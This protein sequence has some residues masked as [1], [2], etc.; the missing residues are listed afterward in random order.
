MSKVAKKKA[1]T[2]PHESGTRPAVAAPDDGPDVTPEVE[3]LIYDRYRAA[4]E[5]REDIARLRT[6]VMDLYAAFHHQRNGVD[7]LD[8]AHQAMADACEALE[9]LEAGVPS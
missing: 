4:Q 9:S 7:A 5:R 8:G 1:N 6:A 3:A 2:N